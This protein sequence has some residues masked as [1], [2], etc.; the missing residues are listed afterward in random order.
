MNTK[1]KRQLHPL[2]QILTLVAIFQ[3][4]FNSM[5]SV[6]CKM[7]QKW[8][9]SMLQDSPNHH[10]VPSFTSKEQQPYCNVVIEGQPHQWSVH[11]AAHEH[12]MFL[13]PI[14]RLERIG[15]SYWNSSTGN[16]TVTVNA[17]EKF[18][19]KFKMLLFSMFERY[20]KGALNMSRYKHALKHICTYIHTH[21]HIHT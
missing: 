4:I 9:T 5:C 15:I 1:V 7:K 8:L 13:T 6:S 14:E 20:L 18:S 2:S 21:M 10:Q 17:I 3:K 16:W 11:S 19:A 12:T